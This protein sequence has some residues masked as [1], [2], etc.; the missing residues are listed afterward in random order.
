[1]LQQ[2]QPDDF[3]VATGE[4]HSVEEF[5]QLAFEHAGLG[6]WRPYVKQDERFMRP[7]EVDLLIGDASKA[8]RFSVG[9]RKL[10]SP[11]SSRR[12]WSTTSNWSAASAIAADL[13]A[14]VNE[15]R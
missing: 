5:V 13:R 7:S 1:M 3:V 4:A 2:D 8:R 14:A 9:S 11:S 6:D 15:T 10:R 12:W